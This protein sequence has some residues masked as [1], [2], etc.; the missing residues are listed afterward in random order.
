MTYEQFRDYLE[1]HGFTFTTWLGPWSKE[2][3]FTHPKY[4]VE[5]KIHKEVGLGIY[6]WKW[7]LG[8]G[9]LLKTIRGELESI[10]QESLE[11]ALKE[12]EPDLFA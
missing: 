9:K 11:T 2:I 5:V 12:I 10:S 4:N 8:D 1:G 7:D 6:N 3:Q